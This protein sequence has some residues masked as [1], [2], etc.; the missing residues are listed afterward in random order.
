MIIKLKRGDRVRR[1]ASTS[2]D[3]VAGRYHGTVSSALTS[4]GHVLVGWDDGGASHVKRR[5][6]THIL[7]K[8]K[9][10]NVNDPQGPITHHLYIKGKLVAPGAII[11][12]FRGDPSLYKGIASPPSP[13]KSGKVLVGDPD[14]NEATDVG[15]NEQVY[16]PTV[17]DAEIRH[18]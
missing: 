15:I 3:T 17:F 13:G 9:T 1:I 11:K 16:Y 5:T 6:V 2:E 4:R 10:L 18:A 14:Y 8:G 7:V 12:D